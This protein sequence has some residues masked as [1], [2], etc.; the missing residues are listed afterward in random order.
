MYLY[1]PYYN[2]LKV[3]QLTLNI[4]NKS[5]TFRAKNNFTKRTFLYDDMDFYST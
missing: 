3:T 1:I 4:I 2:A 5:N